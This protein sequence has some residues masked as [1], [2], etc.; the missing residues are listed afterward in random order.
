MKVEV[1]HVETGSSAS[2]SI[3]TDT[4]AL[5]ELNVSN[6]WEDTGHDPN[7]ADIRLEVNGALII[8]DIYSD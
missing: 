1:F 7:A 5:V 4:G 6:A 3:T 2:V 8:D